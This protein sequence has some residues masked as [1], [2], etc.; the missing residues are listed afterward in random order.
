MQSRAAPT[1]AAPPARRGFQDNLSAHSRVPT[2]VLDTKRAGTQQD[3]PPGKWGDSARQRRSPLFHSSQVAKPPVP[4]NK[5]GSSTCQE[6]PP[7]KWGGSAR[8]RHSPLFN[9]SGSA[10]PPVL[11]SKWW[12]STQQDGPPGKW[13][14]PTQRAPRAASLGRPERLAPSPASLAQPP[15]QQ[16]AAALHCNSTASPADTERQALAP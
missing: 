13:G 10:K 9:S 6:G 12:G 3:S 7:C 4:P 1:P 5:W 15:A 8:Q 16:Q 2:E 11:P 14:G